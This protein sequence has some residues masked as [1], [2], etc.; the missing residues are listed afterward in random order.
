MA[1]TASSQLYTSKSSNGK[2]GGFNLLNT[3]KENKG[4]QHESSLAPSKQIGKKRRD[5]STSIKSPRII[6]KPKTT[7][8]TSLEQSMNNE[9][10]LEPRED[11]F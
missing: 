1:T 3:S 2:A 4:H 5:R 10:S 6:I 11:T 9:F 7:V 8:V